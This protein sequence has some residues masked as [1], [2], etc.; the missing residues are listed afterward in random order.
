MVQ[1]PGDAPGVIEIGVCYSGN[2]SLLDQALAPLR[3]IGQPLSD[4]VAPV[5]YV[6]LQRAGDMTDPRTIT[7]YVKSGFIRRLGPELVTAIIDGFRPDPRR[8]T[9]LFFQQSS[10]AIARVRPDA[11]AFS[12]RDAFA[13]MLAASVWPFGEDGSE[14]I[15]ATREYWSGLE[16]FTYGFYV[17]DLEPDATAASIQATY[18]QNHERLVA[19]KN[20]YDP[21]N[22]FRMNAN[23]KPTV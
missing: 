19:V 21:T 17:N 16:R 8:T 14:H 7:G 5:D 13:N 20:R 18:Q 12:Q 2:P 11:T 10:G 22:L 6:A 15:R 9:M 4:T 23:V 3:A 1:P